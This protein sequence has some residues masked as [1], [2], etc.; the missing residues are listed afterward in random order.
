MCLLRWLSSVHG[1]MQ[2]GLTEK[3][4]RRISEFLSASK[5]ER[6]PEMLIPDDDE[7]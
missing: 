3:D 2:N 7:K 1:S 4:R 5:Y 6:T